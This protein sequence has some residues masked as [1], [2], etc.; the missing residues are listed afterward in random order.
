MRTTDHNNLCVL[1]VDDDAAYRQLIALQL[2]S[3]DITCVTAATH[4]EALQ[5]LRE[6]GDVSVIV[7]D[8]WMQGDDPAVLVEQLRRIRPDATIIGHSNSDQRQAFRDMG[9]AI[10]AIKPLTMDQFK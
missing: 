3:M 10:F 6:N 1:I 9:V 5:R 2:E 7:L 4:D 8:Y